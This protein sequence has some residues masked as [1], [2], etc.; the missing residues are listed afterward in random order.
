MYSKVLHVEGENIAIPNANSNSDFTKLDA[1]V[2][3]E[4]LLP[5]HIGLY[6]ALV[7]ITQSE[8]LVIGEN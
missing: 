7:S 6:K 1:K 5:H 4:D 3:R 8:C 2:D